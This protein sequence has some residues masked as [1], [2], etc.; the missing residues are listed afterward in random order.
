MRGRLVVAAV[1][2]G[3]DVQRDILNASPA[4]I[5]LPLGGARAVEI[6]G[7][8]LLDERDHAPLVARLHAELSGAV[9]AAG[10]PHSP[11]SAPARS[12]L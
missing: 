9:P 2:P 4:R 5:G 7:A 8:P 1:F 11:L 6:L 12:R 3:V 10:A